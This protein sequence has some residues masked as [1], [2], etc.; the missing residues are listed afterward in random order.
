MD[1]LTETVARAICGHQ[2]QH[3]PESGNYRA[4]VEMNW[5][6]W[7]SAAVAA[8]AAYEKAVKPRY[9]VR[10]PTRRIEPIPLGYVYDSIQPSA[11]MELI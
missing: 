2:C 11:L 7:L 6:Y 10:A 4:W 8:I 5:V 3:K 1:K 9:R